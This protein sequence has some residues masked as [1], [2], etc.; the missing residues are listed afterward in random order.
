MLKELADVI[1]KPLSILF[2]RLWRTPEAPEE[3]RKT[4]VTPIFKKGKKKDP[5][6]YRPVNLTFTLDVMCK[7]VGGISKHVE[8]KKVVR[9]SQHGFIKGNNA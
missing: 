8:E 1:A 3:S 6:N 2:K 7:P 9:S 5:G 4:I